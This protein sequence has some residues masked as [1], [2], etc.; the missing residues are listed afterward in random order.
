MNFSTVQI[1][2]LIYLGENSVSYRVFFLGTMEQF[3]RSVLRGAVVYC[4]QSLSGYNER[5]VELTHIPTHTRSVE[6]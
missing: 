1:A 5:T 3:R 6:G 4:L 2:C